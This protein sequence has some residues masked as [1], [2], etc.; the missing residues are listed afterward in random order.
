M[1][2]RSYPSGAAKRKITFDKKTKVE[3]LPK[4]TSFFSE[5]KAGQAEEEYGETD[6]VRVSTGDERDLNSTPPTDS[7]GDS[8]LPCS[9]CD[10]TQGGSGPQEVEGELSETH[11]CKDD[12]KSGSTPSHDPGLWTTID[13]ELRTYWTMRGPTAC[14]NIEGDFTES[15]RVYDK[16]KGLSSKTRYLNRA[17]FTRQLPNGQVVSREWLIYSPS[18]GK[19]FCFACRLFS[20]VDSA[21]TQ[22]GFNDW[23]HASDAISQHEC[24]AEHRNCMLIYCTRHRQTGQINSK[25]IHQFQAEQSYWQQVLERI[26]AVVKFLAARGLAFRGQDEKIGSRLN[27]N[28]LG[29]LE[30]ISKFDP[31][32]AEHIEKYGNRGKGNPSYLSANVCE[33]L[34]AVMGEKVLLAILKEVLTAKYY[35]ISVDST[36][37]VSHVDQLTF[38]VRYVKDSDPV[39]RFL[40]F[41]PVHSHGAENLADVVVKFL[42]DNGIPLSDCR[43]QTYD[44]ASNM[45]GR[46]SGLQARLRAVNPLAVFVPCAGHSLNLV[47]VKAAE[48][49][50]QVVSFF[51]F[52]RKLYTFFSASTHRWAIL[53]A[54][55]GQHCS[56]VK[57]LSDTRW[58]AHADAVKAL[59]EGYSNIQRALDSLA[60]DVDQSKDTRLEAQSLSKN[61]DKLET[62]ILTLFWNDVLSRFNGVS[63]TVQK[64]DV[65]LGVVVSLIQSLNC[66]QSHCEIS[67]LNTNRR[68]KLLLKI[69]NTPI[70]L[71]ELLSVAAE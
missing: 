2:K 25:L 49:C 47:G 21:F 34:V 23:K 20:N 8:L 5:L 3:S 14:Q 67:F 42:Q 70:A 52:V 12:T 48:C 11:E 41:I 6:T 24:S 51:E 27:G 58:S 38:T 13:E 36:P 35:S 17:S 71:V 60:C 65:N 7:L 33:E 16:I 31:F 53:T 54:S 44:N 55:I 10:T 29:V 62:V 56:V 22:A 43:G 26:V 28:Y 46:Y 39:E 50:I 18:Q 15:A 32:L 1:S 37:D 59:C 40:Q 69:C 45:A 19:V 61:M 66:L 68:R 63:K 64:Q 57:R 30:L 9:S 4:L